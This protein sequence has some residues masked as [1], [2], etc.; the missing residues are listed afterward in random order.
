M[1]QELSIIDPLKPFLFSGLAGC[2]ATYCT[3][4]IDTI[5]LRFQILSHNQKSKAHSTHI[6]ARELMVNEGIFSL[7]KGLTTAISRQLLYSTSRIGLYKSMVD[8]QT[9][10]RGFIDYTDKAIFSLV[11]GLIG[12][13]FAAPADLI[14][15]R[16]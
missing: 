4:F 5:K 7:S 12:T 3:L 15:T 9:S 8:Y 11:S 16:F 14:L 6:I 2:G 1:S 13:L 10:N